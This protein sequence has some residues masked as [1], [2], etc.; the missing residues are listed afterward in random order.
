MSVAMLVFGT[1]GFY[2]Y[3]SCMEPNL[4]TG[5]RV[6]ASKFGFMFGGVKRGDVVIFK[7]PCDPTKNYVKRVIWLP[8]DT[9]EIQS[10]TMYVNGEP[11]R[12]PY[13]RYAAHG[14]FAP[15]RV[16]PGKL[17]VIVGRTTFSAAM[18]GATQI[19]RYTKAIMVGEPTGSSPNFIGETVM[20]RLPYSRWSASISESST[21]GW[22][23][24]SRNS[25]WMTSR[26]RSD[27]SSTSAAAWGR[28]L[29]SR[30]W[31]RRNSSGRRTR[32][33]SSFWSNST[34]RRG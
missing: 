33:T 22:S 12:E 28:S 10:G 17:F 13:K 24:R 11:L 14:D 15:E 31:P 25:P 27:W 30:G 32:R 7:Y 4:K 19:E 34:I 3:G 6:L 5:E 20:V 9:V 2:V 1:R 18:C 26:S 21:I 29:A 8:G 16:Q 23:R